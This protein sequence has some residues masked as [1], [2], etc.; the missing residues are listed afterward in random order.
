MKGEYKNKTKQKW[1]KALKERKAKPTTHA[2]EGL[3]AKEPIRVWVR[4]W[5]G[6][7]EG[8]NHPYNSR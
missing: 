5:K 8:Y 2:P 1:R 4:T 6:F 3:G 7:P